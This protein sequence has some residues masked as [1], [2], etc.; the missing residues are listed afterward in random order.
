M[1][2]QRYGTRHSPS[3]SKAIDAPHRSAR[4]APPERLARDGCYDLSKL[5]VAHNIFQTNYS[6]FSCKSTTRLAHRSPNAAPLR[7]RGAHLCH[8]PTPPFHRAR[9]YHYALAVFLGFWLKLAATI[10]ATPCSGWRLAA[11][12]CI[13][14][15]KV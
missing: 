12:V 13:P 4:T 3:V 9:R 15:S 2:A 7:P 10:R 6:P 8:R 11:F 5:C 1:C 14:H